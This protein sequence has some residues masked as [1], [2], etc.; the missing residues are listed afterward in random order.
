MREEQACATHEHYVITLGMCEYGRTELQF[1]TASRTPASQHSSIRSQGCSTSALLLKC[2]A[3]SKQN[4][5][6]AVAVAE[7]CRNQPRVLLRESI[8]GLTFGCTRTP[9]FPGIPP[10]RRFSHNAA[11]NSTSSWK[12]KHT[13][14]ATTSAQ[15]GSK[16]EK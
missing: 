10:I 6:A 13:A 15:A 7:A 8:K 2:T 14:A 1:A 11:P 4:T 5:A 16:I 3:G 12:L 9:F